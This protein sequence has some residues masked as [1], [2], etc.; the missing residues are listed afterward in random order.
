V[1]LQLDPEDV[2]QRLLLMD[3]NW[4]PQV[5]QG[6]APHLREG[7]VFMDVGAHIGYYSLKAARMVGASVRVVALE[8]NPATRDLLEGNVAARRAVNVVIQSFACCDREC[9]LTLYEGPASHTAT[10]LSLAVTPK[11]SPTWSSPGH[12]QFED[13]GSMTLF[14]NWD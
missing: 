8:P 6:I 12:S 2:V 3:G 9:D 4:E 10:A 14:G 11:G 1:S 5:W 7:C 13:A